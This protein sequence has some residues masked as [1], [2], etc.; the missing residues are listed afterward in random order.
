MSI[1]ILSNMISKRNKNHCLE[2]T[3]LLCIKCLECF[4]LCYKQEVTRCER[5]CS[6]LPV[7]GY[8]LFIVGKAWTPAMEVPGH[9][10]PSKV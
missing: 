8:T 9:T 2:A 7:G 3:L 5:A 4:R 6:D 1:F 10:T